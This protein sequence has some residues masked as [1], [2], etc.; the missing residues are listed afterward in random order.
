MLLISFPSQEKVSP[1]CISNL[2]YAANYQKLR[3][4]SNEVTE[5]AVHWKVNEGRSGTLESKGGEG[6]IHWKVKEGKEHLI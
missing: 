5:G 2:I 4:A 6:A 1:I 3:K